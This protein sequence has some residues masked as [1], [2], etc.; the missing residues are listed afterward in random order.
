[1]KAAQG[2]VLG[3]LA[4]VLAIPAQAQRG[5]RGGFSGRGGVSR[6]SGHVAR[7]S[8]SAG[9]HL[10]QSSTAPV[11]G[12]TGRPASSV[13]I[14]RGNFRPGPRGRIT[15][16]GFVVQARHFPVVRRP[17]FVDRPFVHFGFHHFHSGFGFPFCSPVFGIGFSTRHFSFFHRE[18]ACFP[19]PFFSPFFFPFA[20]VAGSTVLLLP[21]P[22][23]YVQAPLVEEQMVEEAPV[24]EAYQGAE[25]SQPADEPAAP[26]PKAARPLTLL[27]LK[28]GSMY[29]LTDYWL[30]DGRLRY[31]TSYG[32]ENSVPLEQIDFD[33]TVKLNA[34]RGVE[35]V[36]RPKPSTR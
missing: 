19:R 4:L 27:Q 15:Q 12:F 30:E 24:G 35:L 3:T 29:G 25:E 26:Q 33:Q 9:T 8:S 21:P 23:T 14:L 11:R 6:G 10:R 20:P 22:V 1:M 36:L 32:G 34:E 31:R 13:V 7:S 5:G 2:F 17:L 28:D 16:R 18:L